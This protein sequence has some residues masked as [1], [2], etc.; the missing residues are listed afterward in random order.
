V[1]ALAA[2]LVFSIVILARAAARLPFWY[3]ESLTVRLSRLHLP[4]ELWTA[5]T[6]GFEFTPPLIYIATKLGR[7]LPGPETLTA[8]LPGLLGYALLA[9]SLFVFLRRRIGPWFAVS[10]VAFLPLTDYTVRYAIEARAYMLLLGVSGCALVF[11]QQTAERRSPVAP[12]GLAL[13]TALALLLH[14][15]AI[16]LPLALV[17]GELVEWARARSI[18]W[19]VV[20]ALAA[21]APVL[22]LYPILLR[23]SRTVVFGGAAYQPTADKLY[24]AFRSDV[25]R[26]RV[27]AAAMIAATVAAWWGRRRGPSGPP[28]LRRFDPAEVAVMLVLLVSPAI[29]YLYA[30][31]ASGAFMTRY[32]M[33]ALPAI[34]SLLGA[35]LYGLGRGQRIAGQATAAV[36]LAGVLLYFPG[37]VPTSGSQSALVQS[38]AAAGA[39]LDPGVPLVLVNPVDI[40]AFDEQANDAMRERALFVADPD[41]ALKYTGT[42]GI[43]LGYVR[44]EP[45]LK[46]RV[47][48]LAYAALVSDY[49][50]LYLVGKWQALSWVPQQL[51]DDGWT[52]VEIGGTRQAPVFEALRRE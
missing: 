8:R 45:F 27:I 16:L 9:G 29:P 44:G 43:D 28:P 2:L 42:N 23:A 22:A 31:A 51:E 38:L 14:V 17:V 40:T 18:R 30:T 33:F 49:R 35:L 1:L 37:K 21:A 25:P 39:A 15:W 52:L 11:W 34:V 3:D 24:A 41:L 20:W 50:R 47:R 10:A 5:L 4:G 19:R 36:T 48:R 6:S 13:T 46:L 7:L 12:V 26:P 32:A